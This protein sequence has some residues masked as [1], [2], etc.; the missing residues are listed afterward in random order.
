MKKVFYFFLTLL[1]VSVVSCTN[2][3]DNRDIAINLVK[4]EY[5]NVRLNFDSAKLDSLYNISPAAYADSMKTGRK[6]DVQLAELESQIEHLPQA[7]S[8]S[9]GQISAGLTKQ[10]YRLLELRKVKPEFIGWT[11]SNVEVVGKESKI[12]DFNLDTSV[13]KIL[14]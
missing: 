6:L 9:V 1:T 12:L 7:E 13:T 5:G 2:K 3:Q 11:L 10:R 4:A 8:D 14:K